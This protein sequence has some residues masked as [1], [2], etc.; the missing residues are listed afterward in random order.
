MTA[1]TTVE[2][3]AAPARREPVLRAVLTELVRFSRRNTLAAI[4]GFVGLFII[5]VALAAPLLA[6]R[7]PLKAGPRPAAWRTWGCAPRSDD[8]RSAAAAGD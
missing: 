6:P 2:P 7:D 8:R 3:Q 5:F 4:G 1:V